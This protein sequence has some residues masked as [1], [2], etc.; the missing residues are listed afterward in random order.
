MTTKFKEFTGPVIQKG[1]IEFVE[2]IGAG[3]SGVVWSGLVYKHLVAVKRLK[4]PDEKQKAHFRKEAELMSKINHQNICRF[5]GVCDDGKDFL[6][7]TELAQ[8]SLEDIIYSA[9]YSTTVSYIERLEILKQI[10]EGMA[11]LHECKV[12]H[13]DLKPGNVLQGS[14]GFFKVTDFGYSQYQPEQKLENA[15]GGSP[16]YMSPERL[17]D[18]YVVIKESDIYSFAIMAWETVLGRKPFEKHW[19][20]KIFTEAVCVKHERPTPSV[21][22][23]DLQNLLELAW[24]HE[25]FER[26][27]FQ[28]ILVKL[29]EI[30]VNE[31]IHDQQGRAF[32]KKYFTVSTHISEKVEWKAFKTAFCDAT[33]CSDQHEGLKKLEDLWFPRQ[34]PTKEVTLTKFGTVCD[35]FSIMNPKNLNVLK[36]VMEKRWFYSFITENEATE[37][38]RN[39]MP[40]TFLVRFSSSGHHLVISR[41]IGNEDSPCDEVVHVRIE[42]SPEGQLS[43]PS[44]PNINDPKKYENIEDLVRGEKKKLRVACP[45]FIFQSN[46]DFKPESLYAQIYTQSSDDPGSDRI[47]VLSNVLSELGSSSP[48]AV[49]QNLKNCRA[50]LL[51]DCEKKNAGDD[52][53][54]WL[55]QTIKYIS[56]IEQ[57]IQ[58]VKAGNGKIVHPIQEL[59]S[60]QIDPEVLV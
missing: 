45:H 35:T 1:D 26:P 28:D 8:R 3:A 4:T 30:K 29:T 54:F 36:S 20:K 5:L 12:V 21:A 49:L 11:W 40:G 42:K 59:I 52:V 55:G 7:V 23:K 33:K 15:V 2:R 24:A 37:F 46:T 51:K 19:D 31:A 39:H 32:W 38:L 9:N 58:N 60:S 10:C 44:N 34:T 53:T 48:E 56:L 17:E 41:T 27:T 18:Y 43:L 16:L 14:D 57:H 13:C 50:R 6:I 22:D 47:F 25:P